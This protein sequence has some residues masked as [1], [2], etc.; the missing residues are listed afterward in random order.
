MRNI[1]I[2]GYGT[3]LL[4]ELR[5]IRKKYNQSKN[6][7][8]MT[9]AYLREIHPLE[10]QIIEEIFDAEDTNSGTV[11]ILQSLLERAKKPT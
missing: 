7:D 5:Q 8:E 4:N 11:K 9:E 3:E 1:R 6:D 2:T 10:T